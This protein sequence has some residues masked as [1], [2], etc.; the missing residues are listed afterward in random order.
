[1]QTQDLSRA[2][3]SAAR[4]SHALVDMS[5]VE[6][7]S[8]PIKST[9]SG[10]ASKSKQ[11][12]LTADATE[13]L[14]HQI[15]EAFALLI[16]E[17]IAKLVAAL[18]SDEEAVMNAGLMPLVDFLRRAVG[19][20]QD[21]RKACA[22]DD[23]RGNLQ[24]L[25]SSR[26]DLSLW[27]DCASK[28]LRG[29]L[30]TAGLHRVGARLSS[31]QENLAAAV[32]GMWARRSIEERSSQEISELRTELAQSRGEAEKMAEAFQELSSNILEE[33]S[34]ERMTWERTL[35][36]IA[37]D[38][39]H[40]AEELAEH[41]RSVQRLSDVWTSQISHRDQELLDL[42]RRADAASAA[43]TSTE[44]AARAREEDLRASREEA[45]QELASLRLSSQ[46]LSH[47][48]AQERA[49]RSALAAQVG[50]ANDTI[51]GRDAAIAE[52]RRSLV[53]EGERVRAFA[54]VPSYPPVFAAAPATAWVT[55]NHPSAG[56]GS[57]SVCRVSTESTTLQPQCGIVPDHLSA[58]P[59][60]QSRIAATAGWPP[61]VPPLPGRGLNPSPA[62][63]AQQVFQEPRVAS[64]TPSRR[65]VTAVV[66]ESAEPVVE[67][68]P[69]K[70]TAVAPGSPARPWEMPP[71]DFLD[72]WRRSRSNSPA[73]SHAT[74]PKETTL[75]ITT[76][77]E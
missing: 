12:R 27:A 15:C 28:A 25:L 1:V 73:R 26:E 55:G 66:Q 56:D 53:E 62:A 51:A 41:V 4:A 63:A 69:P 40:D 68:A 72:L 42:R 39:A 5:L 59:R 8:R 58:V 9:S 35:Q 13:P 30:V 46:D 31:L 60:P 18:S 64:A 24:R 47:E 48:L 2:S 61:P 11:H 17:P 77:L 71:K 76:S 14:L 75:R 29:L 50:E 74:A 3:S 34:R 19:A 44:T 10:R 21:L 45:L 38:R 22:T 23:A 36:G 37:R 7:S 65:A 52:L 57:A 33:K 49:H 20:M 70:L 54:P 32:D 67:Q 43:W 16:Q 6:G